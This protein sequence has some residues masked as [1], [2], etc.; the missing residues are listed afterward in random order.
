MPHPPHTLRVTLLHVLPGVLIF[1]FY[2]AAAPALMRLGFLRVSALLLAFLVVGMPLQLGIMERQARAE[3]KDSIRQIIGLQQRM[4]FWLAGA[5][6]VGS[7]A[8]A[9]GVLARLPLE[10]TSTYLAENVFWWFPAAARPAQT[11]A[12][13]GALVLAILI[14]Q[15]LID[16]IA[17]PVVEE[18]Y[19]RGF[20][21]PRLAHFGWLAPFINTALFTVAHLWQPY[22]YVTI[23]LMVLPLTLI[24]WWR[25]SIYVQ[26]VA[27]CL[28]NTVGAAMSL[29]GYLQASS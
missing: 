14:L 26:M 3:G 5:L 13:A 15:V 4:P 1:L 16:G 23:F 12:G 25:K 2:I 20:L 18:V 19:F 21:L 10:Q 9:I 29:I 22:N 28:A 8:L 6:V 7:F 11:S 27:H 24:T 17:N